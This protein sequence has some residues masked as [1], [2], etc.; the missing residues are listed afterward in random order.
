MS[1]HRTSLEKNYFEM[2]TGKQEENMMNV[3][4]HLRGSTSQKSS[5]FLKKFVF[6]ISRN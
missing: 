3:M 1:K 5:I 2:F 6:G 4:E